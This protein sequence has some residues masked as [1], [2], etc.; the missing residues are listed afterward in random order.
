MERSKVKYSAVQKKRVGGER[1]TWGAWAGESECV[2]VCV[3][4]C[5]CAADESLAAKI[6]RR[7]DR[8]DLQRN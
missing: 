7:T 2:C 1:S 4:V 6:D 5:V 8:C 3:C